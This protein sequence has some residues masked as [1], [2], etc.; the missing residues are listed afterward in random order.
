MRCES[1]VGLKHKATDLGKEQ[2]PTRK[3]DDE[4]VAE[5]VA[6]SAHPHRF[7]SVASRMKKGDRILPTRMDIRTLPLATYMH[8]Y[9]VYKCIRLNS[10]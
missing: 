2:H 8:A 6:I 5:K 3:N 10:G 9:L 1:K 7:G 4:T